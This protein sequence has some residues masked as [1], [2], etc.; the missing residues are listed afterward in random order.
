MGNIGFYIA[1]II[2]KGTGRMEIMGGICKI[3]GSVIVFIVN[4]VLTVLFILL[5][6]NNRPLPEYEQSVFEHHSV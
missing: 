1:V 4:M 2:F 6:R 3:E 5:L